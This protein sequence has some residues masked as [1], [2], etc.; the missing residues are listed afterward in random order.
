MM[1][2]KKN[3]NFAGL[4]PEK[5]IAV[6]A[7]NAYKVQAANAADETGVASLW[8]KGLLFAGKILGWLVSALVRA[9]HDLHVY[10]TALQI[11]P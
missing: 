6:R 8:A 3:A 10:L 11:H 2:N 9:L 5:A 4:L 7:A 1:Y